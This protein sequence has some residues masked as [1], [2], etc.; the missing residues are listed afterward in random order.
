MRKP[1]TSVKTLPP[2]PKEGDEL[3]IKI[4]AHCI[5]YGKAGS[6]SCCPVARAI[7]RALGLKHD[8][9]PKALNQPIGV[10]YED[11]RIVDHFYQLNPEIRTFISDF[12]LYSHQIIKPT[13]IVWKL[14]QKES[15]CQK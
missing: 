14:V 3:K 6:A 9:N 2:L 11:I 15:P 4:T 1:S 10:T 7:K 13:T 5:R 8:P 12:D